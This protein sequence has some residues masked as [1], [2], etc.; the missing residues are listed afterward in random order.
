MSRLVRIPKR[1]NADLGIAGL[2]DVLSSGLGGMDAHG[3]AGSQSDNYLERIAKYIPG[4]VL[5]FFI[6]INAILEQTARIGGKDAAM[7]G[8]PVAVVAFGAVVVGFVL[9]PLFVWYVREDGD[10]WLVNAIVSTLAFP[11]WAYAIG[12]AA[13]NDYWDGNLAAILLATFTVMSGLISPRAP[14]PKRRES[15]AAPH[16]TDRPH[17]DLVE[18]SPA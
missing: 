15:R 10:A 1:A 6:F 18:P 13:F 17:L 5:A 8:V 14:R 4:E 9:T 11:F 16:R 7:A 3:Q 2:D 12:A